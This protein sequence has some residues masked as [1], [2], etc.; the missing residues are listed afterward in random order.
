[1]RMREITGETTNET[2]EKNFS[3]RREADFSRES[4]RRV[5]SRK[6]TEMEM[7]RKGKKGREEEL[8]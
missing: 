4:R 3:E 2:R 6:L 5:T 7:N 1:M 8:K